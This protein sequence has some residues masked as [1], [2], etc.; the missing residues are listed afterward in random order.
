MILPAV[1]RVRN[2]FSQPEGR[3]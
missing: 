2:L 1:L 3:T